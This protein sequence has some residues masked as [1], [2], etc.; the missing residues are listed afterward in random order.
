MKARHIRKLR[1]EIERF[2]PYVVHTPLCLF[3]WPYS[4]EKAPVIY[5]RP[6]D[7]CHAVERY[8]RWYKRRYKMFHPNWRRCF[9][10]VTSANGKFEVVDLQTGFKHYIW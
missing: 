2:H 8:C 6:A 3:G 5:A 9:H 4:E 1:K 10:E 7:G